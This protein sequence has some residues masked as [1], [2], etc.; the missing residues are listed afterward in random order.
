MP[1]IKC[2]VFLEVVVL[3]WANHFWEMHGKALPCNTIILFAGMD[4]LYSLDR[5]FYVLL[6]FSNSM[7][8]NQPR[9][10]TPCVYTYEV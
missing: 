9:K 5:I 2:L 4:P 6:F 8:T 10:C 3:P 1:H 7:P